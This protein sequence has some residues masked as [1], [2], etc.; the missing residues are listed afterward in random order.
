MLSEQEMRE[1]L[2][3][4]RAEMEAATEPYVGR[5]IGHDVILGDI[6]HEVERGEEHTNPRIISQTI[7]FVVEHLR[8]KCVF[9]NTFHVRSAD[10]ED[11]DNLTMSDFSS[12]IT[13]EISDIVRSKHF[14]YT[15][16]GEKGIPTHFLNTEHIIQ[17]TPFM[18]EDYLKQQSTF[19]STTPP[20]L[21]I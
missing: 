11:P 2:A 8:G 13:E 5:G 12:D 1:M 6:F 17:I 19:H 21:T 4:M 14:F 18:E 20:R 7:V 10:F 9:E 3:S 15:P 16:Y